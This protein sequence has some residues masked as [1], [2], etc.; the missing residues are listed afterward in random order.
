MKKVN[1]YIA[2]K[3]KLDKYAENEE[4]NETTEEYKNVRFGFR[5]KNSL[6]EFK[7]YGHVK[8]EFAYSVIKFIIDTIGYKLKD[9]YLELFYSGN[10]G[11]TVFNPEYSSHDEDK[12]K[13]GFILFEHPNKVKFKPWYDIYGNDKYYPIVDLLT[14]F[15]ENNQ[16]KFAE[17][18]LQHEKNK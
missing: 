12:Y 15:I 4:L 14:K 6:T 16:H 13:L 1:L 2:E 10:S 17:I 18:Y 9:C 11:F 5:K 7:A 3:L 8:V